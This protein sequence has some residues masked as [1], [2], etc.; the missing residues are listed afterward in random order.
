MAVLDVI[1]TPAFQRRFFF[2]ARRFIAGE[3]VGQAVDAVSA[4]NAQ[5]MTAT[6]D[7]LGEDVTVEAEA[8]RTV[9]AYAELLAE[10]RRRGV[11]ANV[12]VK[13][14][15]MGLLI[16]EKLA[17]ANLRRVLAEA[18]KNADPFVRIDMEGSAV[19]AATLRL[20][21]EAY[22]ETKHVGPVLQAYLKRTPEDVERVIAL[23]ARVRL[24]KGAYA[25]PP[26]VAY[27][28]MPTIRR[29]YLRCAE[30]LL[31]R[32]NYPG[33]ATHDPLL[34]DAVRTFAGER[35]IAAERFEFQMLY[36]VRPELQRK[37]VADGYRLRVYVPYG[38]H[39]AGYFYRRITERP[40]NALFALRSIF[41]R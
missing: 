11:D 3:S 38:T 2:L 30:M 20:F 27:K 21:E 33:I 41:S 23:G 40:E 16:D 37:L 24:C 35:G 12:S 29:Q 18:A 7:F 8:Q 19:T 22:A 31:E 10:M 26:D 32:G 17:L 13:L 36:G 5:G 14:T 15:A 9:D 34:I 39:W 28:D 4:L 25:E 1:Q 6:C